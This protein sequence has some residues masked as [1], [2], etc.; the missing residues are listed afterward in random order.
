MT[1]SAANYEFSIY[2]TFPL[3]FWLAL[4]AAIVIGLSILL[5]SGLFKQQYNY[6]W[7]WVF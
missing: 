1:P 6:Q 7:I 5:I 3:I 4:I 2:N